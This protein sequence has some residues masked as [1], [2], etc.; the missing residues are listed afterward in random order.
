MR[1]GHVR[2][3]SW[4]V[5]I[6]TA[7]WTLGA[8]CAW[9]QGSLGGL[10]GA[11]RDANGV[12]PGAQVALTNQGTNISRNTVTNDVGE[13]TFP[14]VTPGVYTVTAALQG[15][16]TFERSGLTIATQQFITLD[17]TL[18]VAGI[19]EDVVVTGAAPLV[20]TSDASLGK[21]LDAET[22]KA[23][24]SLTRN[25]FMLAQTAPTY[26]A[27]VDP[28][29]SRMQDQSGTSLVSLGGARTTM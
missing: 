1:A 17:I 28:R 7:L 21:V 14:A 15:F 23:L 18:E 29:Q 12:V 2:S 19:R 11:V 6:A 22:I 13:Y 25:A 26:S 9:A 5:A 10:R 4:S 24:P 3:F 27:N 16:R 20:E 8:T